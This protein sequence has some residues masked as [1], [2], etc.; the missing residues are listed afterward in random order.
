MITRGGG[1]ENGDGCAAKDRKHTGLRSAGSSICREGLAQS[2]HVIYLANLHVREIKA[3]STSVWR[4]EAHREAQRRTHA[5]F[6][7]SGYELPET[8]FHSCL[9]AQDRSPCPSGADR[10][11]QELRR[12]PSCRSCCLLHIST[13]ADGSALHTTESDEL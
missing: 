5:P 13:T 11:L 6:P 10:T 3:Q 2:I 12:P 9:Q 4:A 1:K 8:W 7:L